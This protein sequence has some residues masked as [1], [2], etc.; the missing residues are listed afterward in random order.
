MNLDR[1]EAI[2]RL[3]QRQEH[4]GEIDVEGQNWRLRARK[5]PGTLLPGVVEVLPEEEI[6]S[7]GEPAEHVIR[8]GMVGIYRAPELP[9]R[10]GQLVSAGA[11]VGSIDSMRI[12]NPIVPQETGYVKEVLVEDGDPVEYGQRLFV[13]AVEPTRH[14]D[15]L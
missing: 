8:A 3:L 7:P 5:A 10:S 2:L 15:A 9:I 14:E 12:L 1:I 6:S 4:V 11:P 13:L